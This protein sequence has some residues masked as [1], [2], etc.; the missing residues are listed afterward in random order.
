MATQYKKIRDN[1]VEVRKE[2]TNLDVFTVNL[3]VLERDIKAAKEAVDRRKSELASAEA[4]LKNL[5]EL[6]VNVKKAK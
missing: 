4:N 3:E 5:E 2:V 6:Q 1:I